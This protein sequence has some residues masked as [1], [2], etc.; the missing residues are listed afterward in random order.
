MHAENISGDEYRFSQDNR[1]TLSRALKHA[2]RSCLVRSLTL[3][4]LAPHKPPRV[5]PVHTHC[6]ISFVCNNS[7]SCSSTSYSIYVFVAGRAPRQ[8]SYEQVGTTAVSWVC[9]F[10]EN[11]GWVDRW[12]CHTANKA[13]IS[14]S[15][16]EV[17]H[18]PPKPTGLTNHADIERA[19][20]TPL[21]E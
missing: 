21:R 18:K 11:A 9:R 12:R 16:R 2:V 20:R 3:S 19:A 7:R 15:E 17:S 1:Q 6:A 13:K 5:R 4:I 8:A 14:E 10:G